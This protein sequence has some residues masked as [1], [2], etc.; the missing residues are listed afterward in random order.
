MPEFFDILGKGAMRLSA[1]ET[2]TINDADYSILQ[3]NESTI[4]RGGITCD[5]NNNAIITGSSGLYS[6]N[7]GVDAGF[8]GEIG[9]MAFVNGSAY[10]PYPLGLQGR[11]TS[12][13][14]SIFWQS[15]VSLSG[16]DAIDI[17]GI[18][19]D[20]GSFNCD[21]LRMYLCLIKEH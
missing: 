3:F 18:N 20:N 19:L 8:S 12:R 15:T 4:E 13:P 16:G 17:R 1:P 7:I 10:S 9:I 2:V 14:V 21:L 11:G 5:L 6:V